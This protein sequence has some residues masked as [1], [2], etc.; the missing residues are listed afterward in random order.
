MT[1]TSPY[2]NAHENP[3]DLKKKCI[4][5]HYLSEYYFGN[6]GKN[7]NNILPIISKNNIIIIKPTILNTINIGDINNNIKYTNN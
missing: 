3:N 2:N 5:L 7:N 4:T 1:I 6:F